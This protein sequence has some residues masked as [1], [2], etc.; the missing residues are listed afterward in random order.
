MQ[1]SFSNR[2]FEKEGMSKLQQKAYQ[3]DNMEGEIGGRVLEELAASVDAVEQILSVERNATKEVQRL[4]Q[5]SE[6]FF[7]LLSRAH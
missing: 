6:F 1:V 4:I 7:P 3:Q 5:L 2:R